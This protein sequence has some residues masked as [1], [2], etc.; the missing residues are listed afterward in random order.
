MTA[1]RIVAAMCALCVAAWFAIGTRQALGTDDATA[2]V[3]TARMISPAQA[4]RADALLHEAGLL[5]P[6]QEVNILRGA[7]TLEAG[8]QLAA[9]RIFEAVTRAE[10]QNLEAWLWLA[11]ASGTN[12]RLFVRALDRVREL[13]PLVRKRS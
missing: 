7:A 2:I 1:V 13:E 8:H 9:Q 6:D 10:P 3:T 11:H 12:Q 5:N 4:R